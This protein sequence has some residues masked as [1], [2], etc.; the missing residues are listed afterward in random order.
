[1]KKLILIMGLLG[2]ASRAMA[3]DYA[4]VVTNKGNNMYAFRDKEITGTIFTKYCNVEGDSVAASL[5][6]DRYTKV[7][8]L[9]FYNGSKCVVKK[10][11]FN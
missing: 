5:K 3:D 8:N 2:L 4:I 7:T 1:M 9:V 10:I 6:Q 11:Q